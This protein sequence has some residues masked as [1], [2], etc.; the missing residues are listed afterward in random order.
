L[1]AL[2]AVVLLAALASPTPA[3]VKTSD[4]LDLWTHWR[5]PSEQGY[6]DGDV[7]LVWSETKNVL[8]KTKLP[9]AGHSSPII[10]GDRIYLTGSDESGS[11]R[12]VF[13]VRRSDGKVLWERTAVTKQPREAT[14]AWNGYASASCATDG[15]YVYAFFGT[16]GVFCYDADGTL[17]W[18][19]K[20]GI[21]TSK[22]GW[23]HGASP[24]LYGDTVILNCDN[25]G[26]TGAA[27]AAL[28]ALDKKTGDEKW[29]TPRDQGRGYGTPRLMKTADG[30]TDLVLNGPQGVWGYDP[31]TGKERWRC[32]RSHPSD[33][34]QFGEPLPVDDG[35]RIFILSGRTGPYQLIKMPG[36]GDVTKT[37]VLFSTDRGKRDVAS[38]IIHDGRVYC[39]DRNGSLTVFDMKT[40][41]PLSSMTLT[42]RTRK[43]NSMASPIRVSGKL[44]WVLDEGTTV[45]V[46]PGETP[47]IV[48][49]N[50][51]DGGTLDYGASPAVADGR[52]FI[53][54]RTHLYCIG[55]KK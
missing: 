38:P 39:V 13:C 15:K 55:E 18:K 50:K 5:G 8:W 14:H 19:K 4:K 3:D 37:N 1:L 27:P 20:L 21:F 48:G 33:Q 42:L 30:R 7:P 45:V 16:P 24:Y 28:L 52:L 40:C 43:A 34:H 17:V 9:A 25:D 53:R 49:R 31:K 51:L 6:A 46:E 54:S 10:Y 35:E 36:T 26:G 44:L 2:C 23:G 29:S 32:R 47:K 22:A 12:Y 41:K 11:E